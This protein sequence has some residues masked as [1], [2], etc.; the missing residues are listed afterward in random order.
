MNTSDT[1]KTIA[2]LALAFAV[3]LI[4]LLLAAS[5]HFFLIPE[6]QNKQF[7]SAISVKACPSTFFVNEKQINELSRE[8]E[9]LRQKVGKFTPGG[10]F[11]IVNTTTN[12]FKLYKNNTLIRSGKCSTG[13]FVQLEM[14]ST[15]SWTFETPKGALSVK[16][17]IT[18]P[19]WRKPDWAFVEDGLPIPP[20]DHHSR[21]ERGVLGDYA[22]SLGDGYLIHG[23]LYQRL[24]GMPVTHGCIHLGF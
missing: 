2:K 21:Y 22:L 23:T 20:V 18:D 9:K 10:A 12:S 6:I 5:A 17:K 24:L 4:S 8:V 13:S 11:L 15:K 16:G 3:V 1:V 19:V 14:D 7:Q